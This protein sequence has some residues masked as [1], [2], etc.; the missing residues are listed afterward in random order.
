M[1]SIDDLRQKV[2]YGSGSAVV[3]MKDGRPSFKMRISDVYDSYI[4]GSINNHG[5]TTR[6]ELSD[7]DS[8]RI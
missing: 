6:I 1:I 8:I 4:E 7:I 3:Q 5:G 2:Q